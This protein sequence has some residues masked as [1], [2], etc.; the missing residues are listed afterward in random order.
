MVQSRVRT[1][2]HTLDINTL[3]EERGTALTM[4][5]IAVV[6][7]ET[8]QPIVVDAYGENRIT[9][10]FVLIDAETNATAAAGMILDVVDVPAQI[11]ARDAEGPVTAQERFARWGHTGAHLTLV[12]PSSFADQVE[13]ALFVAGA[14]VVRATAGDA[15]AAIERA[16]A[17]ILTVESSNENVAVARIGNR[18]VNVALDNSEAADAVLDLLREAGILKRKEQP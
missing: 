8:S 16:G 15:I 11:E 1:L 14:F 2:L 13:R 9:G 7:I 10:S 12:G 6:E 17:I 18:Q 3:N 5:G 4:N